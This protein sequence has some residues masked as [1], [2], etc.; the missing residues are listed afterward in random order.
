MEFTAHFASVAEADARI[1][2]QNRLLKAE[3]GATGTRPSLTETFEDDEDPP[4][5]SKAAKK[6]AAAAAAK[7]AAAAAASG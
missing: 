4:A 5:V 7:K 1:L 2:R 3:L 6:K